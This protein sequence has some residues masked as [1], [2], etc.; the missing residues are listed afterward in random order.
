MA[1]RRQQAQEE[2][3]AREL[4]LLYTSVPPGVPQPPN[5]NETTTTS[6]AQLS[7]PATAN[8]VF[9]AGIPS[10]PSDG[11]D[12]TNPH[13]QQRMQFNGNSGDSDTEMRM[14]ADRISMGFSPDRAEVE[15]PGKCRYA[16][17]T[18]KMVTN[19]NDFAYGRLICPKH[20]LQ[21]RMQ[22]YPALVITMVREHLCLAAHMSKWKCSSFFFSSAYILV[23]YTCLYNELSKVLRGINSA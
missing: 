11:L 15:S 8:G 6:T 16:H 1:L 22:S 3:E 21:R 12:S 5:A 2:N 10:P 18:Y 17:T 19:Y 13:H 9:H 4:G 20:S 7:P 14:R 23:C